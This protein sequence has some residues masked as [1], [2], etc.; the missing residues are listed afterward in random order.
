MADNIKLITWAGE[1]VTPQY[2]ALVQEVAIA[3][4]GI[5]YGANVTRTDANTL[6]VSAGYGVN[7]GRFFQVFETDIIIPLSTSGTILGQLYIHM[8]LASAGEPIQ[9]LYQTGAS[10]T[11]L[12]HDDDI[13]II[14]GVNDIQL[15]TFSLNA[16]TISNIVYTADQVSASPTLAQRTLTL[17]STGWSN[18]T[19]TINDENYYTYDVQV[20]R[21]H[22]ESPI[23]AIGAA[24]TI[25]TAL[26]EA[27]YA[28]INAA[29][30]DQSSN[31]ITFY[32]QT[33][34]TGTITIIAKEVS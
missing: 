11:P 8:D 16:S 14:N 23:L 10:L 6:H 27:N 24:N 15:C 3:T 25:P 28:C 4:S 2:D 29:T 33:K 20:D 12:Q 17:L 26:E 34:P 22:S 9:I 13:N 30:A 18:T 19:V 21:I 1:T 7:K 31:V 5:I 32:A